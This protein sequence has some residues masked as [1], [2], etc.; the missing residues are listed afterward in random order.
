MILRAERAAVLGQPGEHLLCP[1]LVNQNV[2]PIA[3]LDRLLRRTG[4]AR[5]YDAAV[6]GVESVSVA[7][8]G[9]FGGEGGDCD[10][11]V[12]VDN[13][14]LDFMG[15]HL[16]ALGVTTLVSLCICACLNVDPIRLQKMLGHGLKSSRTVHFEGCAATG[17]PSGQD[18]IRI[19]SRVIGVEVGHKRYLQVG[20]LK[21]RDVPV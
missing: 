17:S 8:H 20:G 1:C 2:T 18:K 21:R 6:R 13:S 4:V 16:P 14:G 11:G 19:A 9:G 15:V 5:D 10:V 3:G 12:F 7:L